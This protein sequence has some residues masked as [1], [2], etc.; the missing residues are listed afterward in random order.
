MYAIIGAL[1]GFVGCM[2]KCFVLRTEPRPT[3]GTGEKE[4]RP[5]RGLGESFASF[6]FTEWAFFVIG[7][8]FLIGG[9]F[10]MIDR[11]L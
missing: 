6:Q 3:A 2:L 4:G 1:L 10:G 8:L 9:I 11:W 5:S 7:V